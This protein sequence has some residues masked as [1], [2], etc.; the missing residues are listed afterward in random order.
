MLEVLRDYFWK[1]NENPIQKCLN[2]MEEVT[3]T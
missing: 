1:K 2:G 3:N